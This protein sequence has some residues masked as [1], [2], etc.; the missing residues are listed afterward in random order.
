MRRGF[1]VASNAERLDAS[2]DHMGNF[3]HCVRTR[4]APVAEAE[5]GHR[6]G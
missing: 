6:S 4:K 5:I 3:F 1:V 2:N